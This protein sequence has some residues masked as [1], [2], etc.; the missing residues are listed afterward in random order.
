MFGLVAVSKSYDGKPALQD[1]SLVTPT[2]Q[3]TALIGPSGCGKSTIIVLMTGLL[4]PE[5]GTITF[6]N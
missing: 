4:K 3:T 2:G 5:S 6:E 1:I